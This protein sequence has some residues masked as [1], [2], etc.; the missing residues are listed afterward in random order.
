[1]NTHADTWARHSE[2]R[3]D[4]APLWWF[5]PPL[6]HIWPAAGPQVAPAQWMTAFSFT[7]SEVKVVLGVV[8]LQAPVGNCLALSFSLWP[9][10]LARALEGVSWWAGWEG[11]FPNRT[12]SHEPYLQCILLSTMKN[13]SGK[14]G[15]PNKTLGGNL[16]WLL[17][18]KSWTEKQS[19]AW[20]CGLLWVL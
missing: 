19:R 5:V 11:G 9:R 4:H 16:P 12:F 2:Q 3:G 6:V 8:L 18:G 15:Y 1:M 20:K 14:Q 13:S 10:S 17:L 7:L